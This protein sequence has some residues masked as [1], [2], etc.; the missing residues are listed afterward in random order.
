MKKIL[1]GVCLAAVLG[2]CGLARAVYTVAVR[3]HC[4]PCGGG[5]RHR[6]ARHGR[7]QSLRLARNAGAGLDGAPAESVVRGGL[8]RAPARKALNDART[9]DEFVNTAGKLWPYC[10]K[11]TL[12]G[13]KI[14]SWVRGNLA[15]GGL[16]FD[17]LQLDKAAFKAQLERELDEGTTGGLIERLGIEDCG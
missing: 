1:A 4:R 17:T 13:T 8:C 10:R 5:I 11:L 3:P 9:A 6:G 12:S 16:P 14:I 7:L 15:R 2:S